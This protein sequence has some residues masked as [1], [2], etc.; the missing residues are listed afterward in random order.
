VRLCRRN[1]TV[2][3]GHLSIPLVVMPGNPIDAQIEYMT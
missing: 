3:F 1:R 2:P